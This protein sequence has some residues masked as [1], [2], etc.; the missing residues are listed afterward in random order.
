MLQIV[1]NYKCL[2]TRSKGRVKITVSDWESKCLADL[3]LLV[4]EKLHAPV[5]DQILSY[6]GQKLRNDSR[7]LK[8][9]Y[10]RTK[11]EFEVEFPSEAETQPIRENVNDLKR[12]AEEM[13]SEQDRILCSHPFDIDMLQSQYLLVMNSLDSL[14]V[15]FLSPWRRPKTVANRHFFVQIYGFSPFMKILRFSLKK[16]KVRNEDQQE[17]YRVWLLIVNALPP[18]PPFPP[19]FFPSLPPILP[20]PTI[21]WGFPIRRYF[22]MCKNLIY[23][24]FT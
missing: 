17:R 9:L 3:K 8:D 5:C 23:F 19:S 13:C 24:P 22:F 14:S 2:S 16:Y 1:V 7:S 11:D 12:F 18:Y 21:S 6:Q 20:F 4:E 15:N 10:L